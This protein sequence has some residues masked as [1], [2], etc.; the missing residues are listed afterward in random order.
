MVVMRNLVALVVVL[1]IYIWSGIFAGNVWAIEYRLPYPGMLPDS[2]FYF[3]KVARDQVMLRLIGDSR[4]KAFYYL[5]L[6]DKRLASGE[7]L[8]ERERS[9]WALTAPGIGPRREKGLGSMTMVKAEEYFGQAVDEGI[10]ARGKGEEV[11]DLF[12]KLSVAG[13]KHTEVIDSLLTGVSGK[14]SEQLALARQENESSRNRVRE[15][16]LLMVGLKK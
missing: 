5:L 14:D 15:V 9:W 10:L 11:T 8:A 13:A 2:P 7:M 12:T 3:F 1:V 4:Q 16:F 6:S